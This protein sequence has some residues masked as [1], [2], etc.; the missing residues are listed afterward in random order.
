MRPLSGPV[1]ACLLGSALLF[2]ACD[3]E[4]R[5]A[6]QDAVSG[7]P[8][9]EGTETMGRVVIDY[10]GTAAPDLA[11]TSEAG[12]EIRLSDFEG[13]PL[14]V[15]L[16]ATWCAPCIREMPTLDALAERREGS[17]KV[18]T[19]SQDFQGSAVV[20]PFFAENSFRHLEPWLDED[21]AMLSALESD[22]LPIT[23]LYDEDGAELFRVYGGM[24]WSG[25]RAE[26]L[27]SGAIGD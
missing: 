6:S 11:F 27:I 14:L 2:A 18:L 21:N 4:S 8:S 20:A 7:Q 1:I 25:E 10:R 9:L 3:R 19:V 5:D 15:N 24:D 12:Q 22:S 13:R 17:L 26:T 16:W 23:I